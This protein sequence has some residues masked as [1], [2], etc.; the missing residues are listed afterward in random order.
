MPDHIHA[1]VWLPQLGTLSQFMKQWKQRTSVQAKKFLK[2]QHFQYAQLFPAGDPFWQAGFY[3][4][5]IYSEQKL[6]E[7]LT[8]MHLNP[9]R[10]GL[11]S[12]AIEWGWSSARY[13]EQQKFVGLKV[14]WLGS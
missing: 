10:A 13:Y 4:F 1:I 11:V 12:K 3:D 9:V 5:N 14:E 6:E 2:S 7:K 8:Y